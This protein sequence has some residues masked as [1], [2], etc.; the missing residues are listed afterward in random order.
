MACGALFTPPLIRTVQRG[1]YTRSILIALFVGLSVTDLYLTWQL[2]ETPGRVFYEA[3][4]VAARILQKFGWWGL[5]AYKFACAG[6]MLGAAILLARWNRRAAR[7]VLFLACAC[8][9]VVVGYSGLLFLTH[10]RGRQE[11]L[12][13]QARGEAIEQASR[14]RRQYKNRLRHLALAVAFERRPLPQAAANLRAFLATVDHDP[15]PG[16]RSLWPGLDDEACLAVAVIR[17]VGHLDQ[18]GISLDNAGLFPRLETEFA[19]AFRTALPHIARETHHRQTPPP[20]NG[21]LRTVQAS[22]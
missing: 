5:A 15:L 20:G 3:N 7:R 21:P 8:V 4:P 14:V 10:A 12:A 6:T 18:E 9:G 16:L 13:Q 19:A 2:I 11:L 22:L 17:E 1:S